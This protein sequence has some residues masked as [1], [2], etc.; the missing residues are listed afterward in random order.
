[1]AR[2]KK[3]SLKFSD[4]IGQIEKGKFAPVYFI[5]G[6]E[7]YLQIEFVNTLK[8]CLYK[9]SPENANVERITAKPGKAGDLANTALE[10][11][12][13][14]GSKLL[15]VNEAQ[16]FNKD[17]KDI[18]L[19][20][21]P[22]LPPGNHLVL[23]HRGNIDMRQKYFKY[24]TSKTTWISFLPLTQNSAKFWVNRQL[25]KY[26]LQIDPK[27][28]DLLVDFAGFSYST[29]SEEVNKLSLNFEPGSTI[30]LE[31]IRN[32]GSRSAVFSIFEL[33]DA[34]G[35][36]N[37]EKALNRLNRLLESGEALPAI[38]GPIT[39]HF[40]YLIMIDSLKELK[41]NNMI[42]SRVGVKP[43]F[44]QKCRDQ[45][46]NF[47]GG[48]LKLTMKYI[49]EAE[50]QSRYEKMTPAFILENLVSKIADLQE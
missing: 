47:E 34:L 24:V 30:S 9:S 45:I 39:R 15:I 41:N 21:F 11:S 36:R 35:R 25:G 1:M 10:Y 42:A 7:D 28:L 3:S 37:K 18:L 29:I 22:Q 20:L 48:T 8:R 46:D 16:K 5:D 40:N 43:F 6:D 23:F 44:V 14:G 38:L 50:Y 12:L 17:D 32:Y 26:S 33:T 31:D 27:A 19:K 49:F 2:S 13:F 4:V